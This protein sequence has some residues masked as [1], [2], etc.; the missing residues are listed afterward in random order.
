MAMRTLVMKLWP[1]P[2][3]L[4]LAAASQQPPKQ[5][6]SGRVLMKRPVDDLAD[7]DSEQEDQESD[8]GT[9]MASEDSGSGAPGQVH[10]VVRGDTLW[11]LSQHYL[12]TPW[13]WPKVWSYNPEIA[14]PHWIYPG[15]QV[16]FFGGGEE[17]PARIDTAISSGPRSPDAIDIEDRTEVKLT[18]RIGYR[19]PS[20]LPIARQGFVTSNELEGSG[21]II[22]SSSE[23]LMLSYPETV[24]ISFHNKD[25]VKV[26]DR[27]LIFRPNGE[28]IHPITERP[29]GYLTHVVGM[30][31]VIRK[32]GEV[33]TAQIEA[34]SLDEMHRGDRVGPAGEKLV[35]LVEPRA[36]ERAL[37]GFVIGALVPYLTILG[38]HQLVLIDQGSSH[39]VHAGNTFTV[40][41]RHDPAVNV[42][43]FLYPSRVVDRRLPIEDTAN[44]MAVEVHDKVTVCLLTRS[45]REVVYG[46]RVEMRPAPRASASP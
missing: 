34:D 15:N 14:N 10:T 19:P 17:V 35:A 23:A 42:E 33:A 44:C 45:L 26:G 6:A 30:V 39:G 32:S 27:Y 28:V 9:E 2:L 16:R 18:G 31:R 3:A 22:A 21:T 40:V 12:G 4:F 43:A 38:E 37:R 1:V 8:Q 20:A 36:N 24:Y 29:Y 25:A 5:A 13:Y 11:D 41:R 7:Q 46:D